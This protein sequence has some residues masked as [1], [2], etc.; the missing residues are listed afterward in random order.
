[1]T[2]TLAKDSVDTTEGSKRL[3]TRKADLEDRVEAQSDTVNI[4]KANYSSAE[5][6]S[7]VYEILI[8]TKTEIDK[9]K[10]EIETLK[11]DVDESKKEFQANEEKYAGLSASLDG[12]A[13]DI[14][15]VRDSYKDNNREEEFEGEPDG[16]ATKLQATYDELKAAI[17]E[18]HTSQTLVKDSEDIV[19]EEGEIIPGFDSRIKTLE[20]KIAEDQTL[21]L[22]CAANRAAYEKT[23]AH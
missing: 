4:V 12:L 17:E 8:N 15:K 21:A 10:K 22:A 20:D 3:K 11:K 14:K 7:E 19:P 23:E 16:I 5:N 9:I 18:S 13:A 1:M 6:K 2:G